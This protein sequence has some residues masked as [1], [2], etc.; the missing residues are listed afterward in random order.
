[1]T[2]DLWIRDVEATL[3]RVAGFEASSIGLEAFDASVRAAFLASGFDDPDAFASAVRENERDRQALIARVVVPETWFLRD[4]AP[5]TFLQRHAI[6][7]AR[8]HPAGVLRILSAPCA[9]GE[10]P[11]SI[12]ISLL[13]AGLP[14]ARFVVDA[15]DISEPLLDA[16]RRGIYQGQA[17]RKCPAALKE[18]YFAPDQGGFLVD[19]AAR[20]SVRFEPRNL[21]GTDVRLPSARYD[22]VFCRNL[23][24]YLHRGARRDLQRL[25]GDVLAPDGILVVGHAEVL[26]VCEDGVFSVADSR[27]FVLARTAPG[28]ARRPR[29]GL[30]TTLPAIVPPSRRAAARPAAVRPAATPASGVPG[31]ADDLERARQLADRG[32]LDDARRVCERLIEE[33]GPS[34]RIYFLLGVIGQAAGRY[35]EAAEALRKALYLNPLHRDALLQLAVEHE[36]R[37][38]AAS[39]A[40]LRGRAAHVPAPLAPSLG[41]GREVE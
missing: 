3:S 23:L 24:I 5:F 35:Q 4:E 28:S 9:T 18:K 40:R 32:R 30:R 31:D 29:A 15:V 16:A 41:L 17:F 33:G 27:A 19:A 12:A 8:R 22:I 26:P 20:A 39:A 2:P 14:P 25:L 36:R 10:E 6:E 1:M 11:Y 34:D 38:D 21:A 7:W 13:E 37:G